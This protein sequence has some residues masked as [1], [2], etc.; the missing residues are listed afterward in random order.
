MKPNLRLDHS[1]ILARQDETVHAILELTAPPA[2]ALERPPL[3]IALVIDRSGSMEGRPLDSVRKAVLELL[4]VAGPN[5]RIAVVTFDTAVDTVLPLEHHD[6][7]A[8]AARIRAIHSGGSTNLSAGWLKG[9]EILTS[10]KRAEAIARV[11]VL[12]DGHANAGVTEPDA[13]CTMVRGATDHGVTTSIIGF[14]DGHDEN[15]IAALADAG[16][17]NDYWCAGPDQALNVFTA[18]FAGLASV[19]AQNLSVE[20]R[21]TVATAAFECLNEFDSASV[22]GNETARVINIGDAYGDEVRRL[23]LRF[24]LRPVS[25]TDE[26]L[27]AEL[28]V[29]WASTVGAVSLHELTIP[30]TVNS[31]SFETERPGPDPDVV[32]HIVR[33]EAA[34]DRRRAI[35]AA[36][37]NRFDEARRLA[38][39][40]ADKLIGVGADP[41][42][43]RELMRFAADIEHTDEMTIK[44]MR[45]ASRQTNKGR[46]SRFDPNSPF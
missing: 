22:P 1:I 36:R 2:P 3:D 6:A 26:V 20:V 38:H 44:G 12:T 4:R 15:L 16:Q 8:V 45:S 35:E 9:V 10:T 30:I 46:R 21:P 31:V 32:E 28:V 40:A 27:I 14:A 39:R 41:D 37:K 17:G 19:V 5:D 23:A 25:T 33:L 11:V 18:E 34:D 43:V 42:E 13:L 24:A 7:S 29:R